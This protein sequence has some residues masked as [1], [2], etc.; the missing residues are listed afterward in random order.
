MILIEIHDYSRVKMVVPLG[1][2]RYPSCLTLLRSSI[3]HRL[4][5]VYMGLIIKGTIPTV[6]PL[7]LMNTELPQTT[8]K[9]DDQGC[10]RAPSL[11]WVVSAPDSATMIQ[12]LI[13]WI[14]QVPGSTITTLLGEKYYIGY[15]NYLVFSILYYLLHVLFINVVKLEQP[16]TISPQ[17]CWWKGNFRNPAEFSFNDGADPL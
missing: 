11:L 17:T 15:I 3:K 9:T 10:A 5:K 13:D 8:C 14:V 1:W 12:A 4:H 7:S 16:E 6:P 2:Y